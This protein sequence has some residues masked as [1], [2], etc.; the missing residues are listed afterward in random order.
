MK[1]WEPVGGEGGR[2][3]NLFELIFKAAVPT[4][5]YT[6]SLCVVARTGN[7]LNNLTLSP[8]LSSLCNKTCIIFRL[9]MTKIGK[10]MT[11]IGFKGHNN[12]SGVG[13][14]DWNSNMNLKVC[15]HWWD[16]TENLKPSRVLKIH[17]VSAHGQNLPLFSLS[18]PIHLCNCCLLIP[19]SVNH[20]RRRQ[21]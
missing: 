2:V 7:P 21:H 14:L 11:Q 9:Q 1:V 15:R 8:L 17:L 5:N 18:V 19:I 12:V 20:K 13:W 3:R 10:N 16:T 6:Q 4:L